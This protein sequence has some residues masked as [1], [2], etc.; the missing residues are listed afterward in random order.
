MPS[1][2]TKSLFCSRLFVH[3]CFFFP[4][5]Q[6]VPSQMCHSPSGVS[7]ESDVLMSSGGGIDCV[8]PSKQPD[9]AT[10]G[11]SPKLFAGVISSAAWL[12]PNCSKPNDPSKLPSFA[13]KPYVIR[14]KT[15]GVTWACCSQNLR[16][17]DKGI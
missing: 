11:G 1:S 17:D 15:S 7:S 2:K 6:V 16:T 9:V 8:M 13:S 4:V 14:P 3:L 10:K 5:L 12:M